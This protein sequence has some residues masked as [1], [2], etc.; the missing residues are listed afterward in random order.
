[1]EPIP[2]SAEPS[3][4]V[5]VGNGDTPAS[6]R[7][8]RFVVYVLAVASASYAALTLWAESDGGSSL[9]TGLLIGFAGLILG[10]AWMGVAATLVIYAFGEKRNLGS[11][12][13]W[14]AAAVIP[15][16]VFGSFA[17]SRTDRPTRWR[18]ALSEDAMLAMAE[19]VRQDPDSEHSGWAGLM[20]VERASLRGSCVDFRLGTDFQVWGFVHCTGQP[21]KSY[22]RYWKDDWWRY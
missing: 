22:Y 8:L 10:G 1:M 9:G 13:S 6:G 16:L 17:L 3:V 4:Q 5:G 21:E 20:H 12:G 2:V 18:F 7:L 11:P 14:I 19:R 15:I